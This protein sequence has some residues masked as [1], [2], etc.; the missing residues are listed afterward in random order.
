LP[1]VVADAKATLKRSAPFLPVIRALGYPVAFV[2]QDGQERLRVPWD[3]F[4]VLF[5]G[6]STAWK[7]GPHARTLAAAAREHGKPVHLSRGNTR[8]RLRLADEMGCDSADGTTITRGP[9]KNL[10]Q[11]L[12]WLRELNHQGVLWEAAS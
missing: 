2:A 6:G 5:I 8:C 12:A 1:D 11:M 7:L 4:D 10:P 9:D 3:D